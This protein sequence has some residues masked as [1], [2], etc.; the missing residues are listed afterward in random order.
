M[1]K[2]LAFFLQGEFLMIMSSLSDVLIEGNFWFQRFI[3]VKKWHLTRKGWTKFCFHWKTKGKSC[4]RYMDFQSQLE[5]MKFSLATE[6][7]KQWCN[8][9]DLVNIQSRYNDWKNFAKYREESVGE[10]KWENKIVGEKK[11]WEEK[12]CGREKMWEKKVWERKSVGEKGCKE[13]IQWLTIPMWASGSRWGSKRVWYWQR[14]I[15]LN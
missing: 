4:N 9:A 14:F 1:I 5:R 7:A 13:L 10:K 12:K 11:L 8:K 3:L 2:W 15:Y 6:T